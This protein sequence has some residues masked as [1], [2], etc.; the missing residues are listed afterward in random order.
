MRICVYCGSSDASPQFLAAAAAVGRTLA[1]RGIGV[2]YGGARI[3]TMGAVADAAL[4]AGG[5]VVGVIPGFL[6]DLEIA[7]TGL[8]ELRVVGT[9]HER[10]ALMLELSDA[11]VALPG[12]TG[13]LD[14]LF[15]AWTWAQLGLHDKPV[16]VLN[17]DRFYDPLVA[18][19]DGMDTHGFLKPTARDRLLVEDDLDRLLHRIGG[20]RSPDRA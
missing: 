12:G 19:V 14:E 11:V 1:E 18:M 16:G 17:L 3:G 15:E 13:T 8:T 20:H 9:L 2:V 5:E 4:A 7:H 10:K 6:V